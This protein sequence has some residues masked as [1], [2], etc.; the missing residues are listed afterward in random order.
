MNRRNFLTVSGAAAIDLI[1]EAMSPLARTALGATK[2]DYTIQIAPVSF[3]LSPT[4]IIR[5]VGYN[6]TVPGPIIRMREGKRVTIEVQNNTDMPELIH[7]HGQA[8]SADVDGAQEE[9]T[10]LIPPHGRRQYSFTPGPAGTRWY[11]THAM[12]QAYTDRGAYTG[13][14]GFFLVEPKSEPGNYDR[15]VFLAA[16]HW[17]PSIVHTDRWRVDYKSACLGDRALGYGEPIRV[18]QGQRVLFR[19][20]NADAHEVMR[21]S[22]PGHQFQIISMDGNPVPIID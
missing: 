18:H 13:Q 19:I 5:T 9:G 20:L 8:V 14:Y 12:A 21:L 7:W 17:E 10:P 11:H 6:G 2:P 16:H 15:E 3:E 1:S 22:L 4:K